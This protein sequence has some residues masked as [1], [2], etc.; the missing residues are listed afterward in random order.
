MQHLKI[1][2]IAK[3]REEKILELEKNL[4]SEVSGIKTGETFICP[5]CNYSNEKS[6]K[7]SAVKFQDS[8]KCFNCGAWRRC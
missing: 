8:F 6:K 7:G 3:I 2:Y 1:P 5:I 4:K